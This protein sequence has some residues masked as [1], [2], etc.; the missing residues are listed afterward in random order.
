MTGYQGQLQN[1]LLK[2]EKPDGKAGKQEGIKN[3]EEKPI[4]DNLIINT[5]GD[6][7]IISGNR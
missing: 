7:L 5:Q 4:I 1:Y 3:N 6:G 2:K